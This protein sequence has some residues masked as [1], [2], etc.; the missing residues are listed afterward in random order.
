MPYADLREFLNKLESC[1]KL[2][3][4]AGLRCSIFTEY[5]V[6]GPGGGESHRPLRSQPGLFDLYAAL[7]A[8]F[9]TVIIAKDDLETIFERQLEALG[10]KNDAVVGISTSGNSKNVIEA[11]D[12]AKQMG[13]L[14][15]GMTGSGGK[16]ATV[17]DLSFTV[18]SEVT[19]R[20]QETH[21]TLSHI[22]CDLVDRL[23]FPEKF[24]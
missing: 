14:T 8:G 23:L 1:G 3:R 11:I 12:T 6:Q 17:A 19:A 24:T 22:L 9:D 18:D 21:I 5:L 10:N 20:I 4:I 16:L 15:I 7:P 13:L 2:H